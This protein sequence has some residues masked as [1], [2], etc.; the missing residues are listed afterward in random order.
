MYL[1]FGIRIPA[2]E[3][4][5]D[6]AEAARA[7]EAGGFDY[8]WTLD[9]PLLAGRLLD[10][11]LTLAACAATT[12]RARLGVAVT[13]PFT[14]HPAVTACSILSLDDLSDGRAIL[15]MGSGDSAMRTLGLDPADA[16]GTHRARRDHLRETVQVLN[17][18]FRGD[19]VTFGGQKFKLERPGRRV[20]IYIAATGPRMLELAGELADG[21]ILQ[22]GIYRPCLE[23]ALEHVR[24]GAAKAGRGLAEI[25]LVCS[26]FTSIAEDRAVAIDRAR[27]LAA[28]FYAV[29]PELLEMAGVRV[30]QRQP[31]RPVFPDISH[32]ANYEEAMTEARRY[33]SDEAVEK[34]CLV[35]SVEDCVRRIRELA[36][37]GICQV[38][39]R[40]YL[41]YSL[42]L[43][44]IGIVSRQIIPR[45]R[46]RVH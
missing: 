40:H 32:P 6:I 46:Q 17:A 36:D 37:L 19:A 35:G 45:F 7:A 2:G 27:P 33:V 42:P 12:S 5:R 18:I 34:F 30:T 25:D 22:V 31:S 26:T 43:D 44:L 39:F 9:S 10:P 13:N 16:V 21:V 28:W 29:A 4:L 3:R 15:G 24:Q 11:Y 41:A 20:P 23:R 14:R 38:F 8:V 1:S